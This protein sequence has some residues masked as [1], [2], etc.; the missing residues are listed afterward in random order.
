[1]AEGFDVLISG[2]A[3]VN[4]DFTEAAERDLILSPHTAARLVRESPDLPDPW[5]EEA[6]DLLVRL[7]AAGPGLLPVW[8]TLEE[9]GALARLLPEWER[10]RLLPHASVV[11]RFTVDRHLVETCIEASRMIRRVAR[12]D[13]LLV[14]ALVHDIGKGGLLE[15]SVAGEP[16]AGELA[17]RLGFSASDAAVVASLVRWHLLLAEV[18]TT[19]DLEDPATVGHVVERVSDPLTFDLL[20]VLTEADGRGRGDEGQGRQARH[21]DAHQFRETERGEEHENHCNDDALRAIKLFTSKV[22]DTIIEASTLATEGA[23]V[24]GQGPVVDAAD[25]EYAVVTEDGMIVTEKGV[26]N[27][28]NVASQF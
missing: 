13:L 17:R 6:R 2:F 18:A 24:S 16:I 5:P 8:E 12:P 9:T 10:V 28:D 15:H 4:H 22:A 3:T 21:A 25:G 27:P 26:V 20:T 7:L 11:H 23:F 14:S 1:M 19:R